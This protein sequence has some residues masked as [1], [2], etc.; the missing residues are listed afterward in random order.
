MLTRVGAVFE[1]KRLLGLLTLAALV[2]RLGGVL[3][4]VGSVSAD[5]ER[6]W[7]DAVSWVAVEVELARA[8]LGGAM[9]IVVM[10]RDR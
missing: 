9:G 3:A 6:S 1:K 4:P 8:A 7:L 10:D 2:L 5:V